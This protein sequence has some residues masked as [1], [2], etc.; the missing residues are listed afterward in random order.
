M[1]GIPMFDSLRD[2]LTVEE[3]AEYLKLSKKSV[4][5]LLQDNQIHHRKIGRIYRI[6]KSAI[7]D[8]LQNS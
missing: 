7:A 8:Y 1:E 2:V 6:P 3:T 4:Y 5:A